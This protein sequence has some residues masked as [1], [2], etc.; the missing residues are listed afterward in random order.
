MNMTIKEIIDNTIDEFN[1]SQNEHKIN[2]EKQFLIF[3][4]DSSLDSLAC[5]NFLT[6]LEK[7]ILKHF[8]KDLDMMD[9]IFSANK[10]RISLQDIKKILEDQF[11]KRPT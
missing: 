11:E 1:D 3:G 8:S 4:E 2:H 10:D 7:N 6:N 9:K 5:A